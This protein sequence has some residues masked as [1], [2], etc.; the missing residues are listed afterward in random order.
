MHPRKLHSPPP[1]A[2]V[3]II[4][5]LRAKCIVLFNRDFK[6]RVTLSRLRTFDRN[7]FSGLSRSYRPLVLDVPLWRIARI[8]STP[9]QRLC[10]APDCH[11]KPI[12]HRKRRFVSK[13]ET[14]RFPGI[15]KRASPFA[16][17]FLNAP[18]ERNPLIRLLYFTK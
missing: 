15:T 4:R 17:A 7:R 5:S 6:D 14:V 1:P 13:M 12:A 16:P 8:L 11:I 9:T 3:T 18:L 10:S 2:P